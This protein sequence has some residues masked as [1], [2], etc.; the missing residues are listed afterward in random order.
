MPNIWMNTYNSA[1]DVTGANSKGTK[2]STMNSLITGV[3]GTDAVYR[4]TFYYIY[5]K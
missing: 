5:G 3:K 1:I 4:L 2:Y